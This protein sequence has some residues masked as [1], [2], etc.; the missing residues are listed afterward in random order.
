MYRHHTFFSLVPGQSFPPGQERTADISL[1]W[2][3]Q[4]LLL[5]GAIVAGWQQGIWASSQGFSF[6]APQF[7]LC[8]SPQA[9]LVAGGTSGYDLSGT[10]GHLSSHFI[11]LF[12]SDHSHRQEESP[13]LHPRCPVGLCAGGIPLDHHFQ[14]V[15]S[16]RDQT[17]VVLLA[18]PRKLTFR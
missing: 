5:E 3:V 16:V 7:S 4:W 13:S 15:G 6:P 17:E 1:V 10:R 9:G 12:C 2:Q 14:K 8:L 11:G 18:V